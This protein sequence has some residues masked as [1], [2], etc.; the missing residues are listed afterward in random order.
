MRTLLLSLLLLGFGLKGQAQIRRIEYGWD[1][2]KGHGLNTLFPV[3][4]AGANADVN[5]PIALTGLTNGYHTLF[6][7]T[8]D[9]DKRWSQTYIRLVNVL[10]GG[11]PTRIVR[12]EYSYSQGTTTVGGPYTYTL[13]T[14]ATSVDM[15]VPG[16]TSQLVNGQT[17]VLSI[18]AVDENG[19]RSQVYTKSFVRTVSS[20][21]STKTGNWN[22]AATWTCG[23]VPLV[24]D[25]VIINAGHTVTVISGLYK[26][27]SVAY[28]G[29]GGK[30]L[31]NAG[32]R[33]QVGGN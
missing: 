30:V 17:Y 16:N 1:I 8:Q 25:D 10:I 19:T 33:L 29:Q 27:Q 15:R 2:D 11:V 31:F 9:A 3:T 4:S 32:G 21:A 20:C 13:P 14:P 18:Q 22:D 28:Q 24:S 6:V 5:L 23:H 26:A 7:R 12:L